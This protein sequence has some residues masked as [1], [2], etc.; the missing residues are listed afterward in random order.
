VF[1]P[2]LGIAGNQS[3]AMGQITAP[4]DLQTV[5]L[6]GESLQH[7]AEHDF[8]GAGHC[9]KVWPLPTV[10]DS[11]KIHAPRSLKD[12]STATASPQHRD[13]KVSRFMMNNLLAPSPTGPEDYEGLSRL[14]DSQAFARDARL[15]RL[16]QSFI[17]SKVP[18]TLRAKSQ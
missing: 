17:K 6:Q 12:S 18:G 2:A 10:E 16:E 9:L 3:F 1:P 7:G 5:A 14:P 11:D 15:G 13:T 4:P 8:I